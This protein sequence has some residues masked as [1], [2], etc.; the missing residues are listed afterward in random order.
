MWAY[1]RQEH[2]GGAEGFSAKLPPALR[3]NSALTIT[4]V[5]SLMRFPRRREPK[6][7][8]TGLVRVR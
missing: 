8:L 2:G 7:V 5:Y 3:I 4:G 6:S 1:A